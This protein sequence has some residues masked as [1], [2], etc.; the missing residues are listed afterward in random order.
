MTSH[1]IFKWASKK[2]NSECSPET[3]DALLFFGTS[4]RITHVALSIGG[5]FMLECGGSDRSSLSQSKE[6]LL[7]INAC[8]R[9]KPISNR[10]D[11]VSAIPINY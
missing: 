6:D 8:V 9:I 4:N 3:P 1:G 2:F 5:G 11:F 10:R 7:R